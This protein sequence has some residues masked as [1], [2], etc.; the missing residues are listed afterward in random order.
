MI[1]ILS[2]LKIEKK[3]FLNEKGHLHKKFVS[4]MAKYCRLSLGCFQKLSLL[5]NIILAIL[6]STIRQERK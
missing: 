3:T 2:N 5:F 6:A 4:N 1:K